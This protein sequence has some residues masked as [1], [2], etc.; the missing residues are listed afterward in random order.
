MEEMIKLFCILLPDSPVG[1]GA[2]AC[3]GSP[4]MTSPLSGTGAAPVAS[5]EMAEVAPEVARGEWRM[6]GTRSFT[7]S[8]RVVSESG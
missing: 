6:N 5:P 4:P 3:T 2:F 8:R 7:V 1:A